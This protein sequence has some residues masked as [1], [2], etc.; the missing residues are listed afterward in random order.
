[1]SRTVRKKGKTVKRGKAALASID[2]KDLDRRREWRFNLPLPAQV[3]GT[4]PKGRRFQEK[5]TIENISST[6]AYFC[7]ESGVAVG[8]RLNII[9]DVPQKPS[10][11]KKMKLLLGGITIRLEEPKKRGK[12]QGVAVRFHRDFRLIPSGDPD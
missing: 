3:E 11:P 12:R 9:I 4:L 8:S 1:M 2:P 5:A 10:G 7:L 6:G